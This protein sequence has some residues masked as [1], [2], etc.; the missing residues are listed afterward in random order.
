MTKQQ[1]E[2][3]S[4]S[5]VFNY[6]PVKAFRLKA[7]SMNLFSSLKWVNLFPV[8][9]AA[10]GS[11]P[12]Y[13]KQTLKVC[14]LVLETNLPIVLKQIRSKVTQTLTKRASCWP[15]LWGDVAGR[16]HSN[17]CSCAPPDT[18]PAQRFHISLPQFWPG[19]TGMERSEGMVKDWIAT[20]HHSHFKMQFIAA[21]NRKEMKPV[22]VWWWR[23]LSPV[24]AV[25]SL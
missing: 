13:L 5:S 25:S 21:T 9:G 6:F 12:T 23:S 10:A 14:H 8:A 3:G 11:R 2:P 15:S 22:Q 1:L 4:C 18:R 7:V 20:M 16:N 24:F 17:P 19:Q